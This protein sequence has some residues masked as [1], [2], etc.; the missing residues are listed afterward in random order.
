M[1]DARDTA[2][3]ERDPELPEGADTGEG[4]PAVADPDPVDAD[5]LAEAQNDQVDSAGS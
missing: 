1:T 3:G 5:G 4:R 2:E